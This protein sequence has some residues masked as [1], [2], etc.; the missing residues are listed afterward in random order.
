MMMKPIIILFDIIE[1]GEGEMFAS[2]EGVPIFVAS[3]GR[4][5]EEHY[6]LLPG[7]RES[8]PHH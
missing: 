3:T 1:S 4:N 6:R 8:Q 7:T 2:A 5:G